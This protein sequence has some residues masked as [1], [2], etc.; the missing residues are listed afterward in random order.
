MSRRS[1]SAPPPKPM[2]QLPLSFKPP[3]TSQQTRAAELAVA[4]SAEPTG[5]VPDTVVDTETDRASA[6]AP[7]SAGVPDGAV[8]LMLAGTDAAELPADAGAASGIKALANADAN[9]AAAA[10]VAAAGAAEAAAPSGPKRRRM[11]VGARRKAT[12][13]AVPASE[14][15]LPDS[16]TIAPDQMHKATNHAPATSLPDETSASHASAEVPLPQNAKDAAAEQPS[17]PPSAAT[18]AVLPPAA[19]TLSHSGND[20]AP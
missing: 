1:L 6:D 18:R 16:A 10:N 14:I 8:A 5:G 19:A 17:T 2:R 7:D 20:G 12:A 13:A 3:E 9:A 11:L 4:E 15:H